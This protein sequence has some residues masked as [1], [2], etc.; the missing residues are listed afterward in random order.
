MS[1]HEKAEDALTEKE[2]IRQY[3]EA[4]QLFP[5]HVMK[6]ARE[7]LNLP[8]LG[9]TLADRIMLLLYLAGKTII[10][11]AET[12]EPKKSCETKHY[13]SIAV[14]S[15]KDAPEIADAVLVMIDSL[16][17]N[18]ITILCEGKRWFVKASTGKM[19]PSEFNEYVSDNA[20]SQGLMPPP[21]AVVKKLVQLLDCLGSNLTK[22][23][24]QL[25]E[26]ASEQL[27]QIAQEAANACNN[28]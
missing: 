23:I 13:L 20:R 15:Q 18:A 10:H 26:D 1:S 24:E 11:K 25:I 28:Q 22:D 9:D 5:A 17:S 12:E 16:E 14:R 8:M 19:T 21:V 27:G 6:E 3:R 7:K 4:M 2:M